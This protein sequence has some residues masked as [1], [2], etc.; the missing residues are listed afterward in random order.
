MAMASADD[1]RLFTSRTGA[2]EQVARE[3]LQAAGG[4]VDRAVQRYRA[5]AARPS[6]SRP[7]GRSGNVR[8]LSDYH[9]DD[10]DDSDPEGNEYYAGGEKRCGVM[11]SS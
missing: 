9:G 6:S 10:G 8:G 2:S 4:D 11:L 7:G 5:Q 1:V 3:Q